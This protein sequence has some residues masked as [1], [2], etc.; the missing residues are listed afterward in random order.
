[1]KILKS[2]PGHVPRMTMEEA[3]NTWILTALPQGSDSYLEW[4]LTSVPIYSV[5]ATDTELFPAGFQESSQVI[6]LE[7][8][9]CLYITRYTMALKCG[10]NVVF[11]G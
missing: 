4:M 2:T 7:D 11:H 9:R 5:T 1:M 6:N 10:Y 3:T 8:V